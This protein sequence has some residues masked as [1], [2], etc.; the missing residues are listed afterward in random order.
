M[1]PE[2]RT[3]IQSLLEQVSMILLSENLVR[4]GD[5]SFQGWTADGR[6]VKHKISIGGYERTGPSVERE[7]AARADQTYTQTE[8]K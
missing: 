7:R 5:Y 2:N 1:S 3:K 6:A 4:G 8:A